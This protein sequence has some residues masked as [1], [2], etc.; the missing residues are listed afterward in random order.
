MT[1][2]ER[3][4]IHIL[5]PAHLRTGG[6]EALH[7]LGHTLLRLGHDV[8]MVY[9]DADLAMQTD[10]RGIMV[11]EIPDAVHPDYAAYGVPRA[12]RV[13]DQPGNAVVFP[14]IWSLLLPFVSRATRYLWWLSVDNGLPSLNHMGG[15]DFLRS[16]QAVHLGQSWYALDWLASHGVSGQPLFEPLA[17]DYQALAEAPP[18]PRRPSI[19]YSPK[20]SDFTA[21]LRQ[22]APGLDWVELS[23]FTSQEMRG[24]F[25]TAM[26]YVDFGNHPGR[27]RMPREA[28]ALGCCV[29]TGRRGSAGNDRD[30]PIPRRYKFQDRPLFIPWMLWTIRRVLARYER[31]VEDFAVYRAVIA[32]EEAQF[33]AQ[34]AGIFG[35]LA[36]SVA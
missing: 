35:G 19:L 8:R 22:R 23:G 33:A 25:R 1:P 17:R 4:T 11:P 10:A 16:S 36:G 21:L 20:G 32:G 12:W 27:D 26:L 14:E 30:V 34:V 6:P 18:E 9:I 15:I 3:G 2:G 5:C 31:R 29:I 7:Q 28:A 24:L 13:D